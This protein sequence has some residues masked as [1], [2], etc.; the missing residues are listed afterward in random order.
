MKK[1]FLIAMLLVSPLAFSQGMVVSGTQYTPEELVRNILINSDCAQVSNITFQRAGDY[2]GCN[3]ESL[4]YFENTDVNFPMENGI[5]LSSGNIQSAPGPKQSGTQS[6]T[7][8]GWGGDAE[9]LTYTNSNVNFYIIS[10]YSYSLHISL[11]NLKK[12]KNN[13]SN[14]NIRNPKPCYR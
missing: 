1:F 14:K 11:L 5:I 3:I 9:L 6:A 10:K 2:T 12:N 13:V 4:G 8:S 7:C